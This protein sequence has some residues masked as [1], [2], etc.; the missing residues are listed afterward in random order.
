MIEQDGKGAEGMGTLPPLLLRLRL[1]FRRKGTKC[2]FL[3]PFLTLL[4][5]FLPPFA[6]LPM[7]RSRTCT[8]PFHAALLLPISI[9]ELNCQLCLS[10]C[11]L[12]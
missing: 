6:N 11:A 7:M 8:T 3:I 1:L 4:F 2:F 10:A 5:A 9:E 12:I